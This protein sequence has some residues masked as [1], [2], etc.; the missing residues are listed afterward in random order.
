M[1]IATTSETWRTVQEIAAAKIESLRDALERDADEKTTTQLRAKLHA[2]RDV[3]QW[4]DLGKSEPAE[5]IN[6]I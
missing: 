3:L 4:P 6:L 2:Y 5:G 1:G